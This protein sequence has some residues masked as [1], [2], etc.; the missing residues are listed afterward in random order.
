[1]RARKKRL[2]RGTSN[3]YRAPRRASG[4]PKETLACLVG[5]DGDLHPRA[6]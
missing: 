2:E 4:S 1:M 5:E 6:W 3:G